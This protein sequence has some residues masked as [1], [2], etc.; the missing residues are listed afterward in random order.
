MVVWKGICLATRDIDPKHT[1]HMC[2]NYL[3]RKQ[4]KG[5]LVIMD[6]SPQ[7][8]DL[9]LIENLWDDLKREK[10][11][12]ACITVCLFACIT[13]KLDKYSPESS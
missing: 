1:S 5:D 8:R 13:V 2:K 11:K 4:E 6:F 3:G 10:V 9:N 12:H 7:S